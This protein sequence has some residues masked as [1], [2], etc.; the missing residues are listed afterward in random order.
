MIETVDDRERGQEATEVQSAEDD[1]MT[2]RQKE[3]GVAEKVGKRE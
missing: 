1:R 2:E 3:G